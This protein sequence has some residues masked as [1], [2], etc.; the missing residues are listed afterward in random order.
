MM[1]NESS[2]TEGQMKENSPNHLNIPS[3]EDIFHW[4]LLGDDYKRE[5]GINSVTSSPTETQRRRKRIRFD[6][7]VNTVHIIP[8]H[9]QY[10]HSTKK[11]IWSSPEEII[12]NANRNRREYVSEG[13]NPYSVLEEHEMFYDRTSNELIHPVHLGGALLD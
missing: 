13:K 12:Q 8:S 7:N 5:S 2:S 1:S 9:K 4:M 10:P 11:L 3:E 6:T